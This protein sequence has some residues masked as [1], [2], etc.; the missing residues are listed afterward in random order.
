MS[1]VTSTNVATKGVEDAAGSAPSFF[2]SSGNIEPIKVPHNTTPINEQPTV[3][4][5]LTGLLLNESEKKCHPIIT[6]KDKRHKE[7]PSIN[8]VIISRFIIRHQSEIFISPKAIACIMSVL[9]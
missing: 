6:V 9:A 7:D 5:I 1:P 4:P 2:N 8:P 3:N